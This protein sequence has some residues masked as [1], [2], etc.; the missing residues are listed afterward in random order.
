MAFLR[1]YLSAFSFLVSRFSSNQSTPPSTFDVSDFNCE[2]Q[3]GSDRLSVHRQSRS[4]ARMPMPGM[5]PPS[6]ALSVS[7]DPSSLASSGVTPT[8]GT[9][10]PALLSFLPDWLACN[11]YFSA[12]FGL[13]GVGALLSLVRTGLQSGLVVGRR[14]VLTTLE[15]PSKDHSYQWVMQWL[16]HRHRQA[17]HL[18]VETTYTKS[19][20][21]HVQTSFA[22]VPS[23]G[24]HYMTY[25]GALIKVER[26]REKSVIDLNTGT[27]WET[28]TLTTFA[29]WRGIFSELLSEARDMALTKEE[30]KTIIYNSVGQDWRPFGDPKRIRPFS[31]VVLAENVAETILRDCHEFLDSSQWYIERGIPY[32]RGYLLWGPPGCGKSSFV[33]ALAGALHYNIC[34]LN[35][36]DPFLTDDRL[37]HLLATVPPRALVLLE[38]I[39]GAITPQPGDLD[40]GEEGDTKKRE[41]GGHHSH[42]A[43]LAHQFGTRRVS[44]SGLLNALDGVA[45]TEERIIFMTTNRY[46]VLPDALIRPGRVDMKVFVGLA[47]PEQLRRMYV[48]FFPGHESFADEFVRVLKDTP[49]TMAE[50]QG[51]FMLVRDDPQG[52][53]A[54]AQRI[55]HPPPGQHPATEPPPP[56]PPTHTHPHTHGHHDHEHKDEKTVKD[57]ERERERERV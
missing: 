9:S 20:S 10:K 43:A 3:G 47:Q 12:G 55:A 46:E 49:L 21:G 18:G 56:P 7:A 54:Y 53:I 38:D 22:F 13:V 27:P 40:E 33:M 28:L 30:G 5:L 35:V 37:Q 14:Y 52:A 19:K 39:D 4:A 31:S 24:L 34:V 51:F 29:P 45:A 42:A 48:R 1:W 11:P 6:S 25:N 44:F 32:R 17:R 23:P 16:I 36:S 57:Q 15:I 41:K 2:L 26:E 50:L 8:I